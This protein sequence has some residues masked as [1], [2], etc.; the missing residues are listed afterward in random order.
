M[1]FALLQQIT[2]LEGKTA[3]VDNKK[4]VKLNLLEEKCEVGDFI[5]V[6]A[7]IAVEKIDKKQAKQIKMNYKLQHSPW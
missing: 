1:C 3:I 6:Q 5:L 7:N 4:K 2:T